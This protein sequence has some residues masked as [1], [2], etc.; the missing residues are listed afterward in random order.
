MIVKVVG[1]PAWERGS[2]LGLTDT[3]FDVGNPAGNVSPAQA[4]ATCNI[5]FNDLHTPD[6]LLRRNMRLL[7]AE[8]FASAH[9]REFAR[10]VTGDSSTLLGTVR[11]LQGLRADGTSFPMEM[12]LTD[13]ALDTG[14]LL[15][16]SV[17]DITRPAPPMPCWPPIGRIRASSC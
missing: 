7:L 12:V 3:T 15:V 2:R 17:R 8:P 6:S 1:D 5:R 10:H 11:V 14:H 4:R 13:A 9:Q 16:A